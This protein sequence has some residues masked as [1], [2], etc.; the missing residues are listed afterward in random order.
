MVERLRNADIYL[1]TAAWE[2]MPLTI[3]EAAKL[4]RPM[5]I[6][7]IGATKDLDYHPSQY[8]SARNGKTDHPLRRHFDT[9]H[10]NST[11]VI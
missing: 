11:V 10:S 7:K 9:I 3:L 8:P 5:V 2:G 4:T 6:R 1:H